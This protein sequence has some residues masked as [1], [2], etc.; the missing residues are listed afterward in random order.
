M[1]W[2]EILTSILAGLAACI[3]LVVNLVKYIKQAIKEKNWDKLVAFVMNL[4]AQAEGKFDNGQERKEW[5]L[6]MVKASA[7]TI[8]YDIDLTQVSDL[9]DSLC[10]LTKVVNP[11]VVAEEVTE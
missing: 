8:N 9:I 10:A 3:P 2:Y 7:D 4:M 5:V 6:M 11:P 1:E